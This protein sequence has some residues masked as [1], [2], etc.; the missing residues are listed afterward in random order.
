MNEAEVLYDGTSGDPTVIWF[1][2]GGTTGWAVI[3]VHPDALTDPECRVMNN[4]THFAVGEFYGNEF[5]QVDQMIALTEE[6]PGAAIGL[7]HWVHY[8]SSAGRKDDNLTSLVR[9]NAAFRYGLH[10]RLL[11]TGGMLLTPEGEPVRR[12]VPKV[13]RQAAHMMRSISDAALQR[14]YFAGVDLYRLTRGSEHKRDATRHGVTF[15][16]R[17]KTQ[18]SLRKEAFPALTPPATGA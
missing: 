3:S 18:P 16:K 9:I 15:L 7:E 17:L 4:L 14:S 10:L 5:M 2:G 13:Y 11:G 1:D 12:E 6:W 8:D